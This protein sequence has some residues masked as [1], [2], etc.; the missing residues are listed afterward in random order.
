MKNWNLFLLIMML[1][2]STIVI[3][4]NEAKEQS[5]IDAN[6]KKFKSTKAR[7]KFMRKQLQSKEKR[8]Q[9]KLSKK[10]YLLEKKEYKRPAKE[11]LTRPLSP[12]S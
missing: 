12:L 3:A 10:N 4:P 8:E 9:K 1:P 2:Y 5:Y 6:K 7:E 11:I